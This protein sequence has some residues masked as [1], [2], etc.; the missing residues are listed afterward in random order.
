MFGCPSRGGGPKRS[1][2]LILNSVLCSGGG[3]SRRKAI[4]P[5]QG[6]VGGV[7]VSN[8]DAARKFYVNFLLNGKV[9]L[10]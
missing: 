2:D 5:F 6:W 3:L 1:G 4:D 10:M 9:S 8:I 7:F